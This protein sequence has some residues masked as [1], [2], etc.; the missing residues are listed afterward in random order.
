MEIYLVRHTTPAIEKGICYGQSDIPVATTFLAEA[1][2]V[3]NQLPHALDIVYTSPLS[4]CRQLSQFIATK[5]DAPV[6]GD[7]NLMELNFGAWEMQP[8]ASLTSPQFAHWMNDYVHVRCPEGESY[9]DLVQRIEEF[10]IKLKKESFHSVAVVTH[11]GAIKA[12][13]AIIEKISLEAAMEKRF[14]Y[15]SVVKLLC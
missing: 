15:G 8:W 10:I 14:D 3:V 4:R 7:A 12:F 13:H 9:T 6:I 2:Q 5:I 1:N 11:H